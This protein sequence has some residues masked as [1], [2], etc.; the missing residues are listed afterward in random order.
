MLEKNEEVEEEN[1]KKT[2]FICYVVDQNYLVKFHFLNSV[3]VV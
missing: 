1:T 2:T 3:T